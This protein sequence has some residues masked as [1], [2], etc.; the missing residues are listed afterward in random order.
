MPAL[1]CPHQDATVTRQVCSHLLVTR[2]MEYVK[3]FTGNDKQYHLICGWCVNNLPEA[4]RSLNTICEACFTEIEKEGYWDGLKGQAEILHKSSPL[5]FSHREVRL[6]SLQPANLLAIQPLH[7]LPDCTWI[8]LTENGRLVRIDFDDTSLS[9]ITSHAAP[10]IDLKQPVSMQVAPDGNL[11]VITNTHG[12]AGVVVDLKTGQP[13]MSLKREGYHN[14]VSPFPATFFTRNGKTM[15]IHSTAW[16]RL[17]IS[18]A[19]TG[20]LLTAREP[21]SYKSGKERPEHYLDYFH[22]RLT[23]SP[24]QQRVADDGW[25]WHPVGVIASWNIVDWLEENPWESED[26]KSKKQ[27]VW[28]DYFWEGPLCWIDDHRLAIWGYGRDDDW[29]M[30]AACIYDV[31]TGEQLSWFA[32]VEVSQNPGVPWPNRMAKY[33]RGDFIFDR[34]LFACSDKLGV[35]IWDIEDGSCLHQDSSF[36][37][38]GYHRDAQEF[39]SF[40]PDGGFRISQLNHLE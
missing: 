21:T 36:F 15:L 23:I 2:D 38:I 18:D 12:L 3:Y 13:T 33:N 14:E 9:T 28:R 20:K 37:P 8:G 29:L 19:F 34:Y 17:D 5:R 40:L 10:G 7:S 31:I 24:D 16:N 35:S 22:G 1:S 25:V 4:L 26:G 27:L 39:L 30:P 11:A 6:A 32:G